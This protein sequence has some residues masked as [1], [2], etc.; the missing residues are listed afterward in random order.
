[1]GVSL[2]SRTERRNHVSFPA[3][4]PLLLAIYE[5]KNGATGEGK[6]L[7]HIELFGPERTGVA[8][9]DPARVFVPTG[10]EKG[11]FKKRVAE[12][13]AEDAPQR[14]LVGD[15][16]L[17]LSFRLAGEFLCE[18]P[19]NI[20]PDRLARILATHFSRQL[21]LPPAEHVDGCASEE[22]AYIRLVTHIHLGLPVSLNMLAS[23]LKIKRK[24]V[25]NL[26]LRRIVSATI[27]I[28][29][30]VTNPPPPLHPWER[31]QGKNYPRGALCEAVQ[32]VRAFYALPQAHDM[33]T[34]T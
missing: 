2:K 28:L 20:R 7:P 24:A 6:S 33:M 34:L 32:R 14:N 22:D 27:L 29:E 26:F 18:S 30:N 9:A 8:P 10:E 23:H 1:M 12:S 21:V 4:D 31:A 13:L 19:E 11:T 17:V 3:L 15:Y 5:K 16:M 25:L